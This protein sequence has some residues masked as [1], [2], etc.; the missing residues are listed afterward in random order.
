MLNVSISDEMKWKCH[1]SNHCSLSL[2]LENTNSFFFI[3]KFE[4]EYEITLCN[5]GHL[6][7]KKDSSRIILVSR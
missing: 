4:Q 6:Y 7:K 1:R 2:K 3:Y 5:E